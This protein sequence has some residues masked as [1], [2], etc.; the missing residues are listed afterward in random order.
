MF[1]LLGEWKSGWINDSTRVDIIAFGQLFMIKK[2]ILGL[3]CLQG[4]FTR[5]FHR[6][7]EQ[8][9]SDIEINSV[10]HPPIE[11]F[12]C[13]P[14]W[15]EEDGETN[16]DKVF[17]EQFWTHPPVW[18]GEMFE[19]IGS[20]SVSMFIEG[21]ALNAG[22]PGN[23]VV[24]RRDRVTWVETEPAKSQLKNLK[25]NPFATT[26][27]RFLTLSNKYVPFIFGSHSHGSRSVPDESD[28]TVKGVSQT[29]VLLNGLKHESTHRWKW[30]SFKL[31]NKVE[32]D[33]KNFHLQD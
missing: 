16:C 18:K 2:L 14:S 13:L 24:R 15:E 5:T 31:I 3:H 7:R 19:I 12:V 32:I 28:W 23:C 25:L 4:R 22:S 29:H 9:S 20:R 1:P 6:P 30:I 8:K 17:F 11:M 33:S 27:L 10:N 26:F 21:F